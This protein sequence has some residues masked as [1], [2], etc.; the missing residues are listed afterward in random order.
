MTDTV[1]TAS[2]RPLKVLQNRIADLHWRWR[3][4][5]QLFVG[6]EDRKYRL[7]DSAVPY[8]FAVIQQALFDDVVLRLC[9][10]ADPLQ[11][12]PPSGRRDNLVLERLV[13]NATELKNPHSARANELLEEL[14]TCVKQLRLIRHRAIAHEDFRTAVRVEPLEPV[15]YAAVDR[16]LELA[17]SVARELEPPD[18]AL[19]YECMIAAGD[20]DALLGALEDAGRFVGLY[21]VLLWLGMT[22]PAWATA[23]KQKCPALAAEFEN[24]PPPDLVETMQQKAP[25]PGA[26]GLSAGV[27]GHDEGHR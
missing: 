27:T 22:L 17:T 12:G 18:E 24:L 10:L 19:I 11:G 15:Q 21:R 5:K 3:A 2:L 9:K 8:M 1:D 16:A 23:M 4:W 25:W 14:R 13:R 6:D 26:W 20:G 7:M